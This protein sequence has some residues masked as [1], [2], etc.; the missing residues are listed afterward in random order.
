M[1]TGG[2]DRDPAGHRCGRHP[3]NT[4]D[5]P[6]GAVLLA[7]SAAYPQALHLGSGVGVQFHPEAS[8]P[9]F[10]FWVRATDP[11]SLRRH[12]VDPDEELLADAR[13]WARTPTPPAEPCSAPWSTGSASSRR[14][15]DRV[16]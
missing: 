16:W 15:P 4:W 2:E 8:A 3:N 5:T 10:E 13:V 1:L 7:T 9:L 6:P 12:Q 14:R 11:A